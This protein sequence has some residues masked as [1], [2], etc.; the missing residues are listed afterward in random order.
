[1]SLASIA[2]IS[3]LLKKSSDGFNFVIFLDDLAIVVPRLSTEIKLH[4]YS[5]DS[6]KISRI[7]VGYVI[8]LCSL[9]Y[10]R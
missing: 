6:T 7:C 8:D 3:S 5:L 9:D 4:S 10:L 2:A 1:M